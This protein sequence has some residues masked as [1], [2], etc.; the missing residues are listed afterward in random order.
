[1]EPRFKYYKTYTTKE[2]KDAKDR[3]EMELASDMALAADPTTNSELKSELLNSDIPYE[4]DSLAAVM[5][6]LSERTDDVEEVE[7]SQGR[8]SR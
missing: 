6:C 2:L 8:G 7:E 5:E 3:I 1:M 4:R